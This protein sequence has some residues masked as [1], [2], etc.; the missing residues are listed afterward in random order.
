VHEVQVEVI[1]LSLAHDDQLRWRV[2]SGDL[3]AGCSPDARARKLAGLQAPV[4]PATVVH[5]TSWRP[6]RRG[7]IL[8]YA[9]LPDP[10]PRPGSVHPVPA[11]AHI[12]CST[13]GGSP[14]PGGRD[15]RARPG[16]CAAAPVVSG[17]DQ[18]EVMA[19]VDAHQRLWHAVV[20]H[21]PDVAGQLVGA[22]A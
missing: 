14:H 6:T 9:V 21:T 5:S 17:T 22:G 3:P 12:A 2:A 7:L 1:L 16:P 19:A 20:A 18:P 15:D 4:P 10:D 8:T 11:E 13:E